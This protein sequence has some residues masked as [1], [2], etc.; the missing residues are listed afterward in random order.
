M[1]ETSKSKSEGSL[2]EIKVVLG[3]VYNTLTL[4]VSLPDPKFI[5]STK[6]IQGILS[7]DKTKSKNLE[8]LIERLNHTASIIPSERH[9]LAII[10]Y[11][12]SMMND[13]SRYQFGPNIRDDLKLHI[14]ILQNAHKGILMNLLTYLEPTRINLT[15]ACKVGMGG[16]SSKG[17][18]WRRKIPKEY[19]GR[20]HINL[21]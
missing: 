9:F 16:F 1:I 17:R 20:T 21:L 6:T 3:W 11:F 8:T 19:W 13:F 5:S 10:R 18:A 14:R 7:K 15:D 12:H 4:C 2:E